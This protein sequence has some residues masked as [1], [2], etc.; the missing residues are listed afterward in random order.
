MTQINTKVVMVLLGL[1]FLSCCTSKQLSDEDDI[2]KLSLSDNSG[3]G[4]GESIRSPA[5]TEWLATN[6]PGIRRLLGRKYEEKI[7]SA[8]EVKHLA[9]A[10]TEKMIT[11]AKSSHT[12][13]HHHHRKRTS[14]KSAVPSTFVNEQKNEENNV[15]AKEMN[16]FSWHKHNEKYDKTIFHVDYSG[17]KTHPPKNN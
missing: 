2:M 5:M 15:A 12:H 1:S 6:L 17:P 4:G 7:N 11:A 9:G 3:S 10:E 13:H 8:N 16:T 14:T